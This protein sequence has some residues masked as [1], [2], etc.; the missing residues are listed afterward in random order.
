MSVNK[1]E[2]KKCGRKWEL[3]VPMDCEMT[4]PGRFMVDECEG[5]ERR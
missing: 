4:K 1:Y 3:R 2:C 5:C